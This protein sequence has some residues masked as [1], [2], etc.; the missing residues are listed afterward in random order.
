MKRL[1]NCTA[2]LIFLFVFTLPALADENKK[3]MVLPFAINGPQSYQ[4]LEKSIPQMFSTRLHWPGHIDALLPES[5]KLNQV[6][7]N[8]S[9]VRSILDENALDYVVWGSI[10]VIGENCS[11][12]V[13]VLDKDGK[14]WTK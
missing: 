9:A 6:P 1:L 11:L 7:A 8:E 3:L 12:D 10:T 14:I 2:L 13:R 5:A 4:Y